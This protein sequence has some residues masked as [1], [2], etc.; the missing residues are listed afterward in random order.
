M[1]I[2]NIKFSGIHVNQAS[3]GV[4]FPEE[5]SMRFQLDDISS[6]LDF[7]YSF[8]TKPAF[9]VDGGH[10]HLSIDR[11]NLTVDV[12]LDKKSYKE[13]HRLKANVTTFKI[14]LNQ[15]VFNFEF[16]G[17]EAV[18]NFFNYIVADIEYLLGL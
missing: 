6:A 17:K 9:L 15:D 16:S 14:T 5:N 1:S 3:S 8:A 11:F 7:D 10:S 2:D 12:G 13:S 18:S 4:I